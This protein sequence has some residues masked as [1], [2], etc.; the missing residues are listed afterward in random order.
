[1]Y[2]NPYAKYKTASTVTMTPLEILIA[3]YD[4]CIIEC[5]KAA[6]FMD[7]GQYVKSSESIRRVERIVDELRYALDM[8]YDL[9]RNL[10]DLYV[11]YRTTLVN[12]TRNKDSAAILYLVPHFEG[13]KDSFSR[14]SSL[15]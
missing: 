11:Y 2:Q 3:L 8:K 14:I 9:S 1:M 7:R 12:A 5:K 6:E 15:V 10:R 13:L 4:K